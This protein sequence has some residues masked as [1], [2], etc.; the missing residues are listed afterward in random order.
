MVPFVG[1]L[2]LVLP[3]VVVLFQI[4]ILSN[5]HQLS[6]PPTVGYASVVIIWYHCQLLGSLLLL[7]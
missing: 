6:L 5:L 3:L 1:P 7:P 4:W 2:P